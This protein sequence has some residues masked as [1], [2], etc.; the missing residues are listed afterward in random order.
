MKR[1]RTY[2]IPYFPTGVG[3]LHVTSVLGYLQQ[4]FTARRTQIDHNFLK[5]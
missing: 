2:C 3:S 4:D 5:I 1:K